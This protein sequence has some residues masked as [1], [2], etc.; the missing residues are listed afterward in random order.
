MWPNQAP[1]LRP[2]GGKRRSRQF[3]CKAPPPSV[4]RKNKIP[5]DLVLNVIVGGVSQ[6]RMASGWWW[7]GLWLGWYSFSL[8]SVAVRLSSGTVHSYLCS[9]PNALDTLCF[10]SSFVWVHVSRPLTGA[11][12]SRKQ[13]NSSKFVPFRVWFPFGHTLH[14]R[15]VTVHSGWQQDAGRPSSNSPHYFF[16]T[17]TV[18]CVALILTVSVTPLQQQSNLP[19]IFDRHYYKWKCCWFFR[20]VHFDFWPIKLSRGGGSR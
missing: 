17:F 16:V 2:M 10:I 14:I 5:L 4:E 12:P 19:W 7:G 13:R 1:L 18:S 20:A 6:A 3:V 11:F 15:D 8:D 9:R